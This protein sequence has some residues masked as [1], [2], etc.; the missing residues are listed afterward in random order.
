MAH[1][2]VA[3]SRILLDSYKLDGQPQRLHEA[4]SD[5]IYDN[6]WAVSRSFASERAEQLLDNV[7]STLQNE[8]N[9]LNELGRPS[10]LA[11]NSSSYL[12][13]Q[14]S[15]FVQ[16]NDPS[17]LAEKKRRRSRSDDYYNALVELTWGDFEL[18]CG[19]IIE[20]LGV[21]APIVTKRASDEGIDFYGKLNLD[22]IFY[23][24]NLIPNV[25]KQLSVWLVGQAK[26]YTTTSVGTPDIRSL[27]GS[28]T[29]GRSNVY[30][31]KQHPYPDLNIRVGDPV[32]ALFFTTGSISSRAWR[33]IQNSG[34]IGM[35]GEMLAAFLADHRIGI[36]SES[37]R[38]DIFIDW[39]KN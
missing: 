39:L 21:Q 26:R 31:T 13:I 34:V 25:Q 6:K 37:F 23:P 1:G 2:P 10:R 9:E 7:I 3:I 19:K 35:D 30:S 32:F 24:N 29:L 4:I 8:L 20:L 27:V 33:L 28:I 12:F 17:D 36:D 5:I 22:S 11:F 14:G 38:R 16:P 18:L 15:C